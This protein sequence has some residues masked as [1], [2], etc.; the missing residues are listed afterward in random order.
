[1]KNIMVI[2]GPNLGRLGG[3][4]P[5]IYGTMSLDRIDRELERYAGERGITLKAFQSNSEGAIIDAIEK[6][7]S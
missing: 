3:R 4:E 7:A 1:M 5:E 2:H 6:A